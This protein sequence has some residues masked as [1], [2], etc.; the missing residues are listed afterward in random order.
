MESYWP[1][2]ESR[3]DFEIHVFIDAYRKLPHGRELEIVARRDKPDYF[4]KDTHS[5]YRVGVELTSVYLNDKADQYDKRYPLILSVY[6]N[7]Y[8]ASLIDGREWQDFITVNKPVFNQITP[9]FE[10]VFTSLP[11]DNVLS[12]RQED[13][14]CMPD[15]KA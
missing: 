10:V 3:E 15:N 9:F 4:L 1:N 13:H 11:N 12:V 2:R 7:E 14:I 5:S 8:V 6:V